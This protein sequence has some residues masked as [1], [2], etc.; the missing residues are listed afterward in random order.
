[1]EARN[2]AD[3]HWGTWSYLAAAE[4]PSGIID[5]ILIALHEAVA[6]A[7]L[8]SGAS[9]DIAV[10]VK[11]KRA[12]V[13]VEVTDEGRGID[14]GV[15]IPPKPPSLTAEKGRGLFMIW[16]LMSS[17]QFGR[18][19]GTHLVVVKELFQRACRTPDRARGAVQV[20][21]FACR[22]IVDRLGSC[23]SVATRMV[24]WLKD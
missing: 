7:L 13:V 8:H 21:F 23:R 18:S 22:E 4:V 9:D 10:L 12:N 1:M 2:L 17:V 24:V 20:I 16:S 3:L 6:N 11:A 19:S 15:S 5:D 14:A